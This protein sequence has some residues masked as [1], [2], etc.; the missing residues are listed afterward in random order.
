MKI[1]SLL[2][3]IIFF[4]H[5]TIN[6]QDS[7]PKNKK[8]W[9]DSGIGF[10]SKIDNKNYIAMNLSLNYISKKSLYKLRL[11]GVTEFNI[12]SQSE[13][14]ISLGGLTGM[15][16]SSKFFQV[17]FLGGLGITFN[18]EITQNKIGSTGSGFFSSS[19]YE[20]K[21][22]ASL[23][24]PLEIELYLKP[25]KFWGIGLSIFADINSRKPLFGILFK[26]G[27]GKYR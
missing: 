2:I 17:S 8:Y 23:S 14:A 6:S 27:F 26:S 19:I 1:N 5:S 25:I 20:T 21:K 15:H 18:E 22:Y 9:F 3:I 16:Y 7:I 24:I 12:F 10:T 4:S 11:L 13:N